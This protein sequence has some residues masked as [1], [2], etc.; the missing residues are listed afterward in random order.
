MVHSNKMRE[1]VIKR[2][3]QEIE[4]VYRHIKYY[5]QETKTTKIY[6]LIY[7]MDLNTKA[8]YADSIILIS[9]ALLLLIKFL[10]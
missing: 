2:H 1:E 4:D 10:S 8:I 3:S 6:T 5:Y 9:L 7:E